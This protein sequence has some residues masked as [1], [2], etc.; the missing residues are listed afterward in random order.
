MITSILAKAR[1]I[2]AS[3]PTLSLWCAIGLSLAGS[4]LV[5]KE[6]FR[7][8][9][10]NLDRKGRELSRIGGELPIIGHALKFLFTE[11]RECLRQFAQ[12]VAGS[13]FAFSL[14]GRDVV[15]LDESCQREYFAASELFLSADDSSTC[16]DAGPHRAS[17]S[18]LHNPALLTVVRSLISSQVLKDAE[19]IDLLS[20]EIRILIDRYFQNAQEGQ[21]DVEKLAW[22]A[23]MTSVS[24]LLLTEFALASD[25]DVIRLFMTLDDNISSDLKWRYLLPPQLSSRVQAEFGRTLFALAE[26]ISPEIVVREK[27]FHHD[28]MPQRDL[29]DYLCECKDVSSNSPLSA[30]RASE[31]F[32][33]ILLDFVAPVAHALINFISDLKSIGATP[34][35]DYGEVPNN[36]RSQDPK[37]SVFAALYAEQVDILH[38]DKEGDR[39]SDALSTKEEAE[40]PQILD[41]FVLES[42]RVHAEPIHCVRTAQIDGVLNSFSIEKD[43][44]VVMSAAVG[45]GHKEFNPLRYCASN[46]KGPST[47]ALKSSQS[48]SNS[49]PFVPFGSGRHQC[50]GKL[51]VATHMRIAV[52]ALL[53]HPKNGMIFPSS[54]K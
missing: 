54:W 49:T 31:V 39:S 50:P 5:Y 16:L 2:F 32:A 3:H 28:K 37:L 17:L 47:G 12:Q 34:L 24:F 53:Q 36:L 27:E 35:R 52:K 43:S 8:R 40:A 29:L 10:G 21:V 4:I 9:P 46:V 44:I 25:S 20:G 23:A 22:D 30:H 14:W 42:L 13:P 41:S 7:R 18:T 45:Q 15:M 33:L 11:P 26:K 1:A 38:T 51:F 48:K 19:T 6:L